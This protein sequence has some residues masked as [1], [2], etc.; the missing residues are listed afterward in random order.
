M[1]TTIAGLLERN[2]A[3]NHTPLPSIAERKGHGGAPPRTVI[4]TCCDPRCVPEEFFNLKAGEVVVHRNAGGNI[5]HALRDILILD[6]LV[7]LDEIAIVHHTDCG[8]LRFTDEQLRT[9]LK[10]QTKETHWAKIETMEF[11]AASGIEENL[12]GDLEW[13]HG[14]PLLR[15][16][17]KEGTQGFIFDLKSGKVEKVVI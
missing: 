4:V 17:L 3:I 2:K 7:K 14:N 9:A 12:K 15:E 1:T 8:T 10:K 13:V 6:A 11:G 5:R 16:A